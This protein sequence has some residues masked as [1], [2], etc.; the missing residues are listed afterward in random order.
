MVTTVEP[1]AP[2]REN[3]DEDGAS[4]LPVKS[5]LARLVTSKAP[6]NGGA[7]RWWLV[8]AFVVALALVIP[9]AFGRQFVDTKLDLTVSPFR[10]LGNLLNLWD[11][12]GWFGFLQDQYQGYAFPIAPFFAIGHVLAV[13]SWITERIWIAILMA[14]AFWGVVRLTEAMDIGSRPTRILA[15]VAY[16]FWPTFT[17]LV[18]INTAALHPGVLLPWVL[19][20]L[21][22]GCKGG[23]TLRAAALSALAVLFMGGVNAADTLDVLIMP[24]IF[25]LTRQPSPRR[26]SLAGWWVICTGLATMWWLIPLLFLGKYGFNFLPYTEQSSL[27]TSTMSASTVLQGVGDWVSHLTLGGQVWDPSGSTLV[28]LPFAIV[29][30][31]VAAAVGLF[32]LARRDLRERRFLLV[33][34]GLAVV[35]TTA[36]YWGPLGGPF[37]QYLRPLLNAGLSPFR[38]VYKFEPLIALP[39]VIGIAHALRVAQPYVT[40][41]RAYVVAVGALSVLGIVSLASPFLLGRIPTPNAFPT[42]PKYWYQTADYLSDH[43]PRTTALVLPASSHGFYTW[44]WTIDEPLEALAKSPWIDREVAPYSGGASTR[45]I[46]AIDQEVR[47]GLPQPGL[48]ELLARSGI[49][50]IVLQNDSLWQLSDS[51]SPFTINNVLGESGIA[52]VKSFGPVIKTYAGNNPTLRVLHGGL[53][54]PFPTIQ[55]FKVPGVSAVQTFPTATAAMATGGPEADLQLFNQGVVKKNQAVVL[56]GDSQQAKYAGPL[57][58]V[59]D[60]LRRQ[61]YQ[62]GLVNDNFSYTLPPNQLTSNVG[63]PDGAQQPRQMLPFAGVQH[64]TVA[65]YVGAVS[66]DASSYGSWTLSLPE[67]NPANVFDHDS[68]AGWTAGSPGG[69]DGQWIDIQFNR[70]MNLHGSTIKLLQSVGR[71]IATQIEVTTNKGSIVDH[72]VPNSRRQSIATPAG[73]ASWMKVTF[74]KVGGEV[75]GGASAGI[76]S[77]SVPGLHV[78]P[79]LKPPQEAVGSGAKQ[80]VFSFATTQVD[81]TSILRT[82]PEPVMA[83]TFTTPKSTHA[84]VTGTVLPEKGT[85]LNDL[86]GSPAIK[87]SASSTFDDLPSLR[88]ENLFDEQIDTEWIAS[89]R[90]ATLKMSWPQPKVLSQVSVV[91]GR[92]QITAKPKEILIKSPFGSRLLHVSDAGGA[93]VI[94]FK[95][96]DTDQ[97]QVSFPQVQN[98]SV[99][100]GLG[101]TSVT[102]VGLAELEFPA[103]QQYGITQP[104]AAQVFVRLCGAGPEVSIDGHQYQTFVWGTY[105]DLL[106]LQPLNFEVCTNSTPAAG[107]KPR[108]FA[109]QSV[110]LPAGTHYLL[111]QPST[112]AVAPFTVIGATLSTPAAQQS[113]AP[114]RD[115]SILTWGPENR[116]VRVG[117]GEQSYLEVHQNVNSGWVATLNGQKLQPITLDGWQQGFVVPAGSGGEVRMT[118]QPE[119]LYL[120]GLFVGGL[121]VLLLLVLLVLSYKGK[122][123]VGQ[124][125]TGSEA[126]A[127]WQTAL[128]AWLSVAV[129]AIVI[130]IVG[131]PLVLLVPVLIVVARR[132]PHALPWIALAGM[133]VAGVVSAANPGTGAQS[134]AGA[135][136]PWAQAAAVLSIAAV[137]TPIILGSRRDQGTGVPPDVEDGRAN[138]AVP[139]PTNGA[140]PARASSTVADL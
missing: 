140:V 131:G 67:Y 104:N 34:F 105:G 94:K 92:G 88:P 86:F 12:N 103:L 65:D 128:P 134:G 71:P 96:L 39:L 117:P 118:Y 125:G 6:A 79:Y 7:S 123:R 98:S 27:T 40:K 32:G 78:Q 72:V 80:T 17:I 29:G 122:T 116:S 121:G 23:S 139:G 130:F 90:N 47:T 108:L 31:S 97:I 26:R 38:N 87:V 120:S 73:K 28:N 129:P 106:N 64:Q 133:G 55:I 107:Q 74:V 84:V 110:P 46:D 43:A 111:A 93:D 50:Y 30:S 102:P 77:I 14:V 10:L 138:G 70:P 44:G 1:T 52:Q 89:A 21:V 54:V 37:G 115:T 126:T 56:A 58:A 119:N 69:S 25:L 13:P 113:S 99:E 124:W 68:S 62:F 11:P 4:D 136:S 91:F 85:A 137:L 8:G 45:V 24:V 41:R 83:R 60:T 101:G 3:S 19:I 81:P 76:Q 57:L 109:P 51:P 132:W 53:E 22:K 100:N 33:V 42:I 49:S 18:G 48:P 59:T 127:A 36:G 63:S 66:V 2:T 95:P 35:L 5:W 112:R 82:E 16:A 61:N 75:I 20:P 15:G 135:F 114:A 9:D